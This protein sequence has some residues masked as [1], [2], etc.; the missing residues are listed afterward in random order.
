MEKVE[1][2]ALF[3]Q[4]VIERLDAAKLSRSH[5][6]RETGIFSME[7]MHACPIPIWLPS[8]LPVWALALTGCWACLIDQ[9]PL[10][11]C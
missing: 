9:K 10:L 5:L 6:S 11:S 1:R 2:A 8:L 7:K 3:R 4:R